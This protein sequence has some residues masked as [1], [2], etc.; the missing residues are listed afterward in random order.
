MDEVCLPGS[1]VVLIIS[2]S[3]TILEILSN[4]L[5]MCVVMWKRVREVGQGDRVFLMVV[6]LE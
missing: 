1:L 3:L 6:I 5:I 4:V 2:T